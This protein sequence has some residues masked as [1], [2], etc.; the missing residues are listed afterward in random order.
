MTHFACYVFFHKF[1]ELSFFICFLSFSCYDSFRLQNIKALKQFNHMKMSS[2]PSTETCGSLENS[3]LSFFPSSLLLENA[4]H[5]ALV[6]NVCSHNVES[7][8]SNASGHHM[9]QEP[10]GRALFIRLAI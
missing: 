5:C 2:P 1:R 3:M 7:L 9:C 8:D 4:Q 6:V 10:Q